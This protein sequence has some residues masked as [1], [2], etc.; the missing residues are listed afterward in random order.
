MTRDPILTIDDLKVVFH[1]PLGKV[2]ALRGISFTV[3]RGQTFGLVGESGCGKTVTGLSILS[4]VPP[5]GKIIS[6]RIIFDGEDLRQKSEHQMRNIRGR[7]IAMIFQDPAAAL[8]PVFT[9]GHQLME[10]MRHHNLAKSEELHRRSLQMLSDVEL[11]QPK[12]LLNSYPHHLSGG[13]QQRVMIAMALSSNP[14]L[15]I[16]DEPTTALDVTIQAQILELL[17]KLKQERNISII[18]ITHNM[19]IV[20]ET[21]QK[22]AILYAGRIVEQAEVHDIFQHPYHPYTQGLLSALPSP[23][24]RGND[25]KDI[26][27]TVPSGLNPISGC[28]FASRC[29][30]VMDICWKEHPSFIHH[31]EEHRTA[32]YLYSNQKAN[33]EIS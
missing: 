29:E 32:C 18:L 12:E 26:P 2:H 10:V 15:L 14:D 16:A 33:M 19:G 20:A 9:I 27:G 7:R 28:A 21:C 6:G 5:P 1:T 11:P 13:M 22:V 25:L 4:L 31:N 17:A 23:G 24:S 8:N 30:Y 3:E